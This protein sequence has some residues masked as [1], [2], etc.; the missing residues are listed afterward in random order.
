MNRN[1]SFYLILVVLVVVDAWLLAHPNLLGKLGVLVFKY[2]M[3]RTFSRALATV[4]ISALVSILIVAFMPKAG[5]QTA[6]IVLGILT[7]G[8]IG[9][10]INTI[11]K[12]SS[13][14]YAMTGAGFKTGA[15]LMPIILL[16]IFGNG[17]LETFKLKKA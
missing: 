11:M 1:L 10:L 17:L 14:S 15:I 9:L 12:F 2:D 7:V 4:G 6:L 16:L 13:G 3:I 8:S 5:K